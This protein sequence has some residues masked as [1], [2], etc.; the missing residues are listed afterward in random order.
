ML[1]DRKNNAW[2]IAFAVLLAA[3]TA[4]YVPYHLG[5][6]NGPSGGSWPGLIFGIVGFGMLLFVG[7][8]G[9]R[10]YFPAWRIGRSETWMRGHVWLGLL[11][12]A[13]IFFHGGFKFG[14]PLTQVLMWLLIVLTV[15][16]VYGVILQ[17]VLPRLMT[18]QVKLETVYEQIEHVVAQLQ[19]EAEEILKAIGAGVEEPATAEAG[20]RPWSGIPDSG[21]HKAVAAEPNAG[22]DVL[23]DFYVEQVRPYLTGKSAD[24]ALSHS[25]RSTVMFTN[26]R[27]MLPP[28]LHETLG[29]IEDI[30]EEYRQLMRQKRLHNWLHGWLLVHIP[31]SYA[32][33]VLAIVHAIYSLSY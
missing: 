19:A 32:F 22:G 24:G 1:L 26:V 14:G 27:G 11:G 10:R 31:L 30:C 25:G 15:S 12:F 13:M 21:T 17:Q 23:R 18:S 2:A 8:L 7:L 6:L 3:A 29:D 28:P 16:G 9:F 20:K 4:A 33:L 5:S